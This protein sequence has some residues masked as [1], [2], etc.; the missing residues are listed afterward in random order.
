MRVICCTMF[1]P[2]HQSLADISVPNF[3]KYCN[4]HGYEF[5]IIKI[6]N[7]KW[8]YKKHEAFAEMFARLDE[9][10]IIWYKDVDSI[11]TNMAIP[12][13]SFV[14]DKHEMFITRDFNELNGGSL[15]IRKSDVGE[16]INNLILSQKGKL[17]NEQNAVN[18]L[19]GSPKFNQWVNVLPH[20]S[21]NSYDYGLYPEC[22]EYVGREELGHW[23]EGKSF[24]LHVPALNQSD[25]ISILNS[26]KIMT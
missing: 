10:D 7:D 26:T 24:V 8:A 21:I 4:R 17:E 13:T 22:A 20:P 5:E 18:N 19:I 15:I 12:I 1:S 9:G 16:W 2:S 3:E 25:R 14:D 6:E 11:I 23:V